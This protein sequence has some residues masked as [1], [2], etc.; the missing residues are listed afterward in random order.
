MVDK[1]LIEKRIR[2]LTE[3]I[4][5]LGTFKDLTEEAFLGDKRNLFSAQMSLIYAVE[6]CLDT[7][8]HVIASNGWQPFDSYADIARILYANGLLDE[9]LRE[10]LI[11]MAGFRN[12]AVHG[13]LTVNNKLVWEIVSTRLGDLEDMRAVF[14]TL[15]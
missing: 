12:V 8:A 15:L 9:H 13:Y 6:S 7:G 11:A 4:E 5:F 1:Q 3:Q 14:A 10:T 2:F